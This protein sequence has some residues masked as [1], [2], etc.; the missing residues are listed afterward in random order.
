MSALE[1]IARRT[2]QAAANE[3][4]PLSAVAQMVQPVED[5]ARKTVEATAKEIG[6]F[7]RTSQISAFGARDWGDSGEERS[8]GF[9]GKT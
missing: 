6:S 3:T 2:T 5:T 4:G 7:C 1:D 8:E 9:G